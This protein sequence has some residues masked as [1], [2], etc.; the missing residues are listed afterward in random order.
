MK[1]KTHRKYRTGRTKNIYSQFGKQFKGSQ[2]QRANYSRL[3]R[4]GF[5]GAIAA[6]AQRIR[7]RASA[8]DKL[9]KNRTMVNADKPSID[10]E[11]KYGKS[12]A[13]RVLGSFKRGEKTF[14]GDLSYTGGNIFDTTIG[15][16]GSAAANISSRRKI[17]DRL[18]KGGYA[19]RGGDNI[20]SGGAGGRGSGNWATRASKNP[21]AGGLGT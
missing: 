6:G 12:F 18:K 19:G 1:S 21:F 15:D 20:L 3:M 8:F 4:K 13:D 17:K 14:Q 2:A 9:Y 7:D 16:V 10:I 11:S 5:N